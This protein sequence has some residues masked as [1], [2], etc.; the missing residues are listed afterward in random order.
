MKWFEVEGAEVK[1]DIF[2]VLYRTR[3]CQ[4]RTLK[5]NYPSFY[6]HD[7]LPDTNTD[8]HQLC[9]MSMLLADKA[10]QDMLL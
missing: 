10:A 7:Q 6:R 8:D 4:K 1:E 3:G 9:K 2:P 5:K